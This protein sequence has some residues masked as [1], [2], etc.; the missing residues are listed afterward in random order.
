M[1]LFSVTAIAS[2]T[3]IQCTSYSLLQLG[4]KIHAFSCQPLHTADQQ[5]FVGVSHA[6]ISNR[7]GKLS[8]QGVSVHCSLPR[9]GRRTPSQ[10]CAHH[11]NTKYAAYKYNH[12]I[13]C[14]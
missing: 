8:G 12:L 4:I 5:A 11:Q 14:S 6:Y 9:G 3:T 2:I 1:C 13:R 7:E 10:T